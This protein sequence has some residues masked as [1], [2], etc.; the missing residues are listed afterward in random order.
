[1]TNENATDLHLLTPAEQQLCSSLR[2]LP[3]PYLVMKEV[4]MKEAMKHGG[5]LKK[6][7]AREIC[8]VSSDFSIMTLLGSWRELALLFSR[9]NLSTNRSM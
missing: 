8:R 7:A 9:A 5:V 2:I 3:K 4:L 1:M 6:K